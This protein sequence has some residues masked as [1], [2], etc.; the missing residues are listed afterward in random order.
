MGRSLEKRERTRELKRSA[1]VD[2]AK[3]R[4][5]RVESELYAGGL[6]YDA[7]RLGIIIARLESWQNSR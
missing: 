3:T 4:L 6:R 1:D 5:M 2:E 7:N